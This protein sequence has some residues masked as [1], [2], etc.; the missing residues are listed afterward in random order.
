MKTKLDIYTDTQI[1]FIKENAET[2]AR[3][4]IFMRTQDISEEIIKEIVMYT[5][6]LSDEQVDA[7]LK[8]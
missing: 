7:I 5:F 2:I 8:L 3:A 4:I 1:E 6:Q